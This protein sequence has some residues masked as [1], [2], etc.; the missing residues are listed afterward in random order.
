MR[1]SGTNFNVDQYLAQVEMSA[2]VLKVGHKGTRNSPNQKNAYA[3][4][5]VNMLV[6]DH[7]FSELDKQIENA[8]TF[9]QTYAA[10]L[11]LLATF[12]GVEDVVFDFSIEARDVIVQADYFPPE[13]LQRMGDLGIGLVVSRYPRDEEKDSAASSD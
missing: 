9:L 6:S 8:L 7:K 5:G 12:P 4:S 2:V 1:V 11:R 13:L 10:E 3:F